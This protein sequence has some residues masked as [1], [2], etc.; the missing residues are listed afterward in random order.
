MEHLLLTDHN[1]DPVVVSTGFFLAR[2]ANI[3]DTSKDKDTKV[4]SIGSK[5]YTAT[6]LAYSFDTDAPVIIVKETPSE[7]YAKLEEIAYVY[8][9]QYESAD[10]PEPTDAAAAEELPDVSASVP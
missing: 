3:E 10:D 7:I 6:V 5:K 2:T 1:G 8:D 4:V 9:G